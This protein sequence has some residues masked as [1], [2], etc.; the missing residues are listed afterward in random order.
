MQNP[1]LIPKKFAKKLKSVGIWEVDPLNLF[2]ITWHN[3]PTM[4]GGI[5]GG[6]NLIELPECLTGVKAKI[7]V[8]R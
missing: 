5:Y 7:I 3:E 4:T 2:R 1:S 8:L 6:V